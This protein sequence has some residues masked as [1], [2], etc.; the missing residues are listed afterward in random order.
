M[1]Y[2]S[3]VAYAVAFP[4]SA[5]LEEFLASRP[6]EEL[7]SVLGPQGAKRVNDGT[8]LAYHDG[9]IKWYRTEPLVP[10]YASGPSVHGYPWVDLHERML[11]AARGWDASPVVGVFIRIGEEFDDLEQDSWMHGDTEDMP[12]PWELLDVRRFIEVMWRD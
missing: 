7:E 12:S 2:R 5:A 1:G 6:S 11:D 8:V 10:G 4:T 3:E 9:S